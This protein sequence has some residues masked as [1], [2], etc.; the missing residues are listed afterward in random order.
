MRVVESVL[1]VNGS[2]GKGFWCGCGSGGPG[3]VAAII[4]CRFGN[5]GGF[6]G[7]VDGLEWHSC[8][9]DD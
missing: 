8:I 1:Q 2:T 7:S 6:E 4:S 5:L 9:I 3:V